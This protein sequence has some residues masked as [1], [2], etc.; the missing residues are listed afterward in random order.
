MKIGKET[1]PR[2]AICT[3]NPDTIVVRGKNLTQDLVGQV[4]FGDYFHLLVTG[5][6]PDAT[7]SAVLNATLVAIAEHGL[8]PSVQASRMT[9]AAAPD[10]L[11]G[12]VA[13]GILG[14]GSVILG[15]SEN[16]GY[17]LEE[18]RQRADG[19]T[20]Y[21][22]A[23]RQVVGEYRQAR[24]PLPGYGHPLHKKRD[25]RVVALFRVADQ[26]G[27]DTTYIKIAEAAEKVIPD[28]VGKPLMLNVSAAI[29]AV[30][31]GI[32][33]PLVALKGVPILAR[34][35][36]LIGHLVEEAEKPIGF[37]LSYQ[38]TR[39]VVYEGEAPAGFVPSE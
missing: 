37:A 7:Q 18:I 27:A 4:S 26:A 34:T 36:G 1:T 17:F 22:E 29:P 3:S 5:K 39:E 6:M 20:D 8:V 19:S 33:F 21:T 11:Q 25:P 38:A 31:L 16:C 28:I 35:A 15:A 2:T 24:R 12:A 14:C 9:Y 13:A 30:L 10:A 23:A 32:G